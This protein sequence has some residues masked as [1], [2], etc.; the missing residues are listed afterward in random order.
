M[1]HHHVNALSAFL[2]FLWE[3]GIRFDVLVFV[4]VCAVQLKR[5]KVGRALGAPEWKTTLCS[6]G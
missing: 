2:E 5:E 6:F 3:Y 4:S 1:M